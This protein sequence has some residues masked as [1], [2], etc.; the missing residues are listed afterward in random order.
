MRKILSRPLRK[1]SSPSLA[2]RGELLRRATKVYVPRLGD[3]MVD[4]K[5]VEW[6]KKDGERISKD[7]VLVL[8]ETEKLSYE[9]QAPASGYV[10]LLVQ[11]GETVPVGGVL[12]LIAE[13]EE[14]LRNLGKA[15]AKVSGV[16][17]P[18]PAAVSTIEEGEAGRSV[19]TTPLVKRLAREHGVDTSTLLGTGPGGRIT[20]E[21]VLQAVQK[22]APTVDQAQPPVTS[23]KRLRESIPLKGIRKTIAERMHRSLQTTAQV[24]QVIDID[25]TEMVKFREQLNSHLATSD[26]RVSFDAV[27]VKGAARTL[28][29]MPILNSSIEENEIKVWDDINIGVAVMLN[30]GLIVPVVHQANKKS[31]IEINSNV[32]ELVTKARNGKLLPDNVSGGTFTVDNV[33]VIG[34]EFGTPILN[35]PESAILRLGSIKKRPAVIDDAIVVRQMMYCAMTSD[36]RVIDGATSARFLVRFRQIMENPYLIAVV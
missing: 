4:A 11:P 36:H 35:P 29:E 26:L 23:S 16:L 28:E 19:R 27:F 7:E 33:G 3:I 10:H 34:T 18:P 5:V 32:K 8:I 21:D 14:E 25:M 1:P 31:L 12:A 13:S 30:E 24:T 17:A 20:K 2:S 15:D 22:P 9:V 6:R